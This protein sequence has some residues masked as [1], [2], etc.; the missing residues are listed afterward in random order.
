MHLKVKGVSWSLMSQF[1]KSTFKEITE[2]ILMNF[3][4]NDDIKTFV[5][6]QV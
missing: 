2:Y 1:G 4:S 5:D 3:T 6:K